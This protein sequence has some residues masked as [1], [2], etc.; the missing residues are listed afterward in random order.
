M[1]NLY[2]NK[3]D[4]SRKYFLT[5]EGIS[6]LKNA[7]NEGKSYSF[8]SKIFGINPDTLSSLAKEY[9]LH[10][11]NRR[12]YSLNEKYFDVIDLKEK[13]YWLGFLA[14]DGYVDQEK[15][16]IIIGL[17]ISDKQHIEKF[18]KAIN[19]NKIAKIHHSLFNNK[20]H[21]TYSVTINSKYM[22]KRLKELELFKGKSLRYVPPCSEQVPRC[23]IKY[24]ILGYFDGDGCLSIYKS[25]GSVRYKMGFLGTKETILFIQDFLFLDKKNSLAHNC[26]Q[27]FQF[28][29]T[30]TETKEVLDYLYCDVDSELCLKRKYDKYLKICDIYKYR[31]KK[32]VCYGESPSE[33]T[34]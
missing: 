1:N 29:L 20:D 19:S 34:T 2:F 15:G 22:T 32:E 23:W 5:I 27:T 30:E 10:K 17:Q 28:T 4:G 12:K 13:A 24:W 18:L 26:S 16:V 9:G 31:H 33:V 7:L 25:R 6:Y 3:K 8:I 21:I 14:A 11:D